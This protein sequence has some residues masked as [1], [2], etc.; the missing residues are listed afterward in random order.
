V[1]S[2]FEGDTLPD[3][4]RIASSAQNRVMSAQVVIDASSKPNVWAV[5]LSQ[6]HGK[7]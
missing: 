6:E 4:G 1:G 3:Y 7:H 2:V 5:T